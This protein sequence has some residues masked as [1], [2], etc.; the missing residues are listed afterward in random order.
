MAGRKQHFIPQA[1]QRGFGQ[2]KGKKTQVYVFKKG[3]E[4][5]LSSTEGV[6]AQR[7]FYSEPSDEETLDDRITKYEKLVLSPAVTALRESPLGPVDALAR[8][9]VGD[10][11]PKLCWLRGRARAKRGRSG[12][13][14]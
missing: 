11:M 8:Y 7:D 14:R 3:S 1:L 10:G 12:L 13:R 9:S 4:P 5:Y 6:A 2:A